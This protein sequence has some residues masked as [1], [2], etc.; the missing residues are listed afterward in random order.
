MYNKTETLFGQATI[1]FLIT[2][3]LVNKWRVQRESNTSEKN[4]KKMQINV[5][6]TQILLL[7]IIE[8]IILLLFFK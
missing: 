7:N 6:K 5:N 3:S 4:K 8:I 1:C 2:I